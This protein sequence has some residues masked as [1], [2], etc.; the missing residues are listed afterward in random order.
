MGE[1]RCSYCKVKTFL[2]SEDAPPF[3]PCQACEELAALHATVT[4]LTTRD[5]IA[6][7]EAERDDLLTRVVSMAT[8]LEQRPA[9]LQAAVS[10]A[11]AAEMRATQAEAQCAHMREYLSDRL[12][13]AELNRCHDCGA[14]HGE[15]DEACSLLD[16]AN[17]N[18]GAALLE[19]LRL[20]GAVYE[21]AGA[22][23][24]PDGLSTCNNDHGGDESAPCLPWRRLRAAVDDVAQ[25]RERA[26]QG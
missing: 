1:L 21:R 26:K 18:A 9:E 3:E 15:H 14:L 5:K 10:R 13:D 2:Q 4:E 6:E 12:D 20:L 25:F 16:A 8:R 24:R 19:E 23:L 17:G 11:E 7:L 22:M